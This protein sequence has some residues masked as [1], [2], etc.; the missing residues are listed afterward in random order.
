MPSVPKNDAAFSVREI[1]NQVK[2][3]ILRLALVRQ[4]MWSGKSQPIQRRVRYG[5]LEGNERCDESDG[6]VRFAGILTVKPMLVP[7]RE[8][9]C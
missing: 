3:S 2:E 4:T 1:P 6:Y 8:E 5:T 9:C 7:V